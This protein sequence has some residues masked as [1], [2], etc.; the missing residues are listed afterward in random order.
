MMLDQQI[1]DNINKELKSGEPKE[2]IIQML[3]IQGYAQA[4]IDAAFANLDGGTPSITPPASVSSPI[5]ASTPEQTPPSASTPA[6]APTPAT[7]PTPI[8]TSAPTPTGT[9]IPLQSVPSGEIAQTPPVAS[10]ASSAP[11][12]TFPA[13]SPS[14]SPAPASPVVSDA[15][16]SSNLSL[17]LVSLL[18]G[19][20]VVV[21]AGV[22]YAFYKKIGPFAVAQYSEATF[23]SDILAK[24]S[25]IDTASYVASVKLEVVDR[26]EGAKPFVVSPASLELQEKYKNDFARV[27]RISMLV[28]SLNSKYGDRQGYDYETRLSPP[29]KGKG[30]PAILAKEDLEGGG[31]YTKVGYDPV[32]NAPFEYNA[33]EGG[34]SFEIKTTLET[35]T[36]IA[37]LRK[38]YSYDATSTLVDGQDVTFTKDSK[39]MY[40]SSSAPKP[41]LLI[42]SESLRGISPDISAAIALGA[43]TDFKNTDFPDWRFTANAEGN[44]GDLSYK[45]DAEALKKDKDYYIR[46]NKIPAIIS[47]ISNFKGQWIKITPQA[48]STGEKAASE[49]EFSY[50]S[51][52]LSKA[53]T[54]YKDKRVRFAEAL[55]NL[56]VLADKRALIVFKSKPVSD[57]VD[58]RA[59]TRYELDVNK[60]AIIPFY[61]EVLLEAEKYKDIRVVQDQGL[62]D[63]LNSKDFE[64]TFAFFKENTKI[65][66]WVDGAGFPAILQYQMR[67]V[68]PDTAVQLKEKQINVLLKL[69]FADINKS[70]NIDVPDGARPVEDILADM[71]KNSE[72]R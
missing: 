68:P 1:I 16:A 47:S 42:L 10:P 13:F 38:S 39:S 61:K 43:T 23:I 36:A 29:K 21:S 15:P 11:A 14:P 8:P 60:D 63:Y 6:P 31:F 57:K 26:E 53:E 33:T 66:L 35:P 46:I 2:K 56:A 20:I 28:N 32:T 22:G 30:Y 70:V 55:R 5:S 45:V 44:L 71:K 48:S 18:A 49:N 34:K 12:A 65:T 7:V 62:L 3:Q 69:T 19:V 54:A 9:F 51:D 72:P 67:V 41:L 40:I 59:L 64:E 37:N 50:V 25:N 58:G 4:D 24:V 17:I 52:R 27:Q